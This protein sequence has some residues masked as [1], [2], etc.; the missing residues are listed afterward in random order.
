MS[1]EIE[2]DRAV[3]LKDAEW[4]WDRV[5]YAFWLHGSSNVYEAYSNRRARDWDLYAIGPA[6]L[7]MR[8]A[9]CNAGYTEYGD[10]TLKGHRVKPESY[11]KKWREAIQAAQPV[12]ELHKLPVSWIRLYIPDNQ[13]IV[14][15]NLNEQDQRFLISLQEGWEEG[16]DFYNLRYF[17]RKLIVEALDEYAEHEKSHLIRN[18]MVL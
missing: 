18:V 8:K 12:S 17:E 11:I 3:F 4:E 2:Y 5:Y 15:M 10:L 14:N 16:K 1:Y 7:I 6:G 13:E 9:C